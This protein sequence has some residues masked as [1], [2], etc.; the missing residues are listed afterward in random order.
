MDVARVASAS[1]RTK[2]DFMIFLLF[3]FAFFMKASCD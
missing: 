1:K 2:V 3:R